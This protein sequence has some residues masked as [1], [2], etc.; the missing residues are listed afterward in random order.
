MKCK[1][2]YDESFSCY[3]INSRRSCCEELKYFNLEIFCFC[4]VSQSI[5]EGAAV[6]CE[7]AWGGSKVSEGGA[8]CV[9]GLPKRTAL[10]GQSDRWV[11]GWSVGGGGGDIRF[12]L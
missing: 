10:C 6:L 9:L 11:H 2:N 3:D 5:T 12:Q 4:F 8:G 1:C 7:E